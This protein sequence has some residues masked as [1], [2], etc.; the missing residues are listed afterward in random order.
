MLSPSDQVSVADWLT[1]S[2]R[3][4]ETYSAGSVVPPGYEAYARILHPVQSTAGLVGWAEIAAWAGRVYHPNMQFE[5]IATP[6]AGGDPSTRSS[7]PWDGHVPGPLSLGQAATLAEI[8]RS[9]TR[10]PDQIRCLIWDG[11]GGLPE[12]EGARVRR[13]HRS[14]LLYSGTIGT[15][16]DWRIAPHH[17]APPEYWFPEDRAWCVATDVDLFWTYV[18]GPQAAIADILVNPQLEAVPIDLDQGLTIESD[19]VN[20]LTDDERAAWGI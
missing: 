18:G 13:P 6:V 9:Y 2:L 4:F 7:R 8:L 15:E 11:Y 16:A 1:T 14:Y 10:T 19:A 3:P 17:D 20:R 12:T 5:C